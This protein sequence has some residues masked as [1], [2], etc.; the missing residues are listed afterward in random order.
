MAIYSIINVVYFLELD[1]HSFFIFKKINHIML[2]NVPKKNMKFALGQ[3]ISLKRMPI[4]KQRE[5]QS[6]KK[7]NFSLI[8]T[9]QTRRIQVLIFFQISNSCFF[10]L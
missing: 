8:T 10:S 6:Y 4:K 9:Y 5:R 3:L 7:L 1:N 2:A